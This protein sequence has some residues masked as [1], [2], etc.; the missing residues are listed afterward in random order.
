MRW[1]R[2]NIRFGSRLALLALALQVVLTFGHVHVDG[3]VLGRSSDL[4][5]AAQMAA[6][7][8]NASER[9]KKSQG[10]ADYDCP[11]CALIQ[12][13]STASPAAAPPLPIPAMIGGLRLE[14]A[15]E[16]EQFS[17]P[18]F[19]FRARGPPAI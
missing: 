17:A 18:Y 2:A 5:S 8:A 16:L 11:I 10:A 6:T 13:A 14:T 7:T 1:F 3:L 4:S 15:D 19:A 12:L 9:S